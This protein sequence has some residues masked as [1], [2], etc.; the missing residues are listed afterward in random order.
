MIRIIKTIKKKTPTKSE[1]TF[2]EKKRLCSWSS[3]VLLVSWRGQLIS[4]PNKPNTGT[5]HPWSHRMCPALH[6]V[7]GHSWVGPSPQH[8]VCLQWCLLTMFCKVHYFPRITGSVHLKSLGMK[9]KKRH[10]CYV[11][12][13]D[14]FPVTT[15][16]GWMPLSISFS[17]WNWA[18]YMS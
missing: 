5:T 13:L 11:T 15:K 12:L 4:T 10:G 2:K 7:W 6:Q 18:L 9:R 3:M 8:L 14:F 16:L 17:S 1:A